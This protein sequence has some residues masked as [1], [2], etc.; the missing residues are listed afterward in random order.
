MAG[1]VGGADGCAG[2]LGGRG[3]VPHVFRALSRAPREGNQPALHRR[4]SSTGSNGRKRQV[5][6]QWK[7]GEPQDHSALGSAQQ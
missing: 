7:G 2:P 1:L 3:R 5:G 4:P 6:C